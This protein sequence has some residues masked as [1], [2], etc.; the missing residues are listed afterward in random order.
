MCLVFSRVFSCSFFE[1]LPQQRH[2]PC[3]TAIAAF[4]F[5]IAAFPAAALAQATCEAVSNGVLDTSVQDEAYDD[6]PTSETFTVDLIKGDSIDFTATYGLNE[7][8]KIDPKADGS[9][10]VSIAGNSTTVVEITPAAL[11]KDGTFTAS[12]TGVHTVTYTVHRPFEIDQPYDTIDFS[13]KSTCP[14]HTDDNQ[15]T[16]MLGSVSITLKTSGSGTTQSFG[17][18]SSSNEIG[19]FSLNPVTV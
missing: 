9:I 7:Y 8:S 10:V 14:D 1:L 19:S 4:T 17:F 6:T 5:F 18:A 16:S 12:E 3:F 11:T 13:A 2:W 15:I